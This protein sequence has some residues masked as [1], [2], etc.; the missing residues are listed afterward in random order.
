MIAVVA[1]GGEGGVSDLRVSPHA[2]QCE[3]R[4]IIG[5]IALYAA[6]RRH[7]NLICTSSGFKFSQRVFSVP[8]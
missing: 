1:V 2:F 5:E 3:L 4:C 7:R 8:Q 6:L